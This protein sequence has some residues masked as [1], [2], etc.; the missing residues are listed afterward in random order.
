MVTAW[1]QSTLQLVVA[2][3]Y[4]FGTGIRIAAAGSDNHQRDIVFSGDSDDSRDGLRDGWILL[5]STHP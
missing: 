2:L 4:E 3:S 5:G 1:E